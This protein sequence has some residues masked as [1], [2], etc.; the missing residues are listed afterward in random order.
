MK[1]PKSILIEK[2]CSTEQTRTAIL[3]PYLDTS[4]GKPVLVATSGR[5]LAVVP[6]EDSEN[7]PAG[8]VSGD[9][10][11][12]G[13]KATGKNAPLFATLAPDAATLPGGITMPRNGQ[14]PA[15]TNFPNWRAVVPAGKDTDPGRR[16]LHINAADLFLLSQSL[17]SHGLTLEFNDYEKGKGQSI[18]VRP[19]AFGQYSSNQCRPASP[20]A[21]GVIMAVVPLADSTK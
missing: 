14:V 18:M 10:L 5:I 13:R 3:E 21:F 11:K 15:G 12:A 19:L 6:V 8:F 20:D 16:V 7:E 2:A 1:L 4:N 9:L 17:G